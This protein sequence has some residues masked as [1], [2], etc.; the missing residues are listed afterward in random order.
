MGDQVGGEQCESLGKHCL[1]GTS[2]GGHHQSL[3]HQMG[4]QLLR[5]NHVALQLVA[6][7]EPQWQKQTPMAAR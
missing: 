2:A 6:Q 3:I 4:L 5:S 1:P 7:Q